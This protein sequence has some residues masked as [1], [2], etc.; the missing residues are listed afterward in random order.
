MPDQGRRHPGYL[1]GGGW[2]GSRTCLDTR[3]NAR[4]TR[5]DIR[6]P[7]PAAKLAFPT[8][9]LHGLDGPDTRDMCGTPGLTFL[10]GRGWSQEAEAARCLLSRKVQNEAQTPSS[11][12][13]SSLPTDAA[14]SALPCAALSPL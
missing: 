11:A 14:G 6:P 5:I 9:S 13:A 12:K 3:S 2:S 10:G 4:T 1:T 7:G 8:T